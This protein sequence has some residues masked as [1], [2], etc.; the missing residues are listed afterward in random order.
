MNVIGITGGMGSGKTTI[1]NLLRKHNYKVFDSDQTAK[2]I[3]DNDFDVI[4]KIKLLF[5]DDIYKNNF[6][7]RKTLANIVF[8]NKSLLIELNSIVHP[9]T[10]NKM[11]DFIFDCLGNKLCF[12]ESA[13]MF[14][15]GLNKLMDE[16]LYVT[17]PIDIRI[18][19]IIERDNITKD[20]ILNRINNQMNES[21]LILQSDYIIDTNQSLDNIENTLLGLV[22]KMIEKI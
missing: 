9:K 14:D 1:S 20:D 2:Y 11:L 17:A 4:Q 10:R 21:D 12:V 19:R 13:I 6:L 5:G 16:V 18:N 3:C 8:N 7:D 22:E 15:T